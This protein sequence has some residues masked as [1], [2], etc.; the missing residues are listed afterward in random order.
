[1]NQPA[2]EKLA[3][4]PQSSREALLNAALELFLE[5][6]FAATRVEDI[7]ARAGVSKG[8]VYLYFNTKRE[9]FGAVIESGVVERIA[10]A[11][12]F[13]SGFSG[14]VTDLLV[15]ILRNNLLEFWDSRSSGILRLIV[16]EAKQFPDLA[17]SFY[18]EVTGRARQL[19]ARVLQMG[20]DRGEYREID[21]EY[22]A[23]CILNALDFEIV[24]AHSLER[25]REQDFDPQRYVETLIELILAGVSVAPAGGRTS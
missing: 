10:R 16:A 3:A 5:Q 20:I 17:E 15:T 4:E 21:V 24:I 2:S 11:E 12:D 22:T 8:T 25:A 19:L 14:S 9:L 1:M 23:R 18:G 7:A 6:G 13:A